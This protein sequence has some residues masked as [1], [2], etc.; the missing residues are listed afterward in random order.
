MTDQQSHEDR[1][2]TIDRTLQDHSSA[3]DRH[4]RTLSRLEVQMARQA[5]VQASS[6][7][8]LTKLDTMVE[9]IK[10]ELGRNTRLADMQLKLIGLLILVLAAIAGVTKLAD[11]GIF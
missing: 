4:S 3:L 6:R 11:V 7:D 5:E 9:S 8:T 1:F 2:R 10:D